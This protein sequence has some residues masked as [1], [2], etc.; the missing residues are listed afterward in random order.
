MKTEKEGRIS[1]IIRLKKKHQIEKSVR[2]AFTK[3]SLTMRSLEA[4]GVKISDLEEK[5]GLEH[6]RHIIK[7]E[8]A[9]STDLFSDDIKKFSEL[10]YI[11]RIEPV[12]IVRKTLNDVHR[13]INHPLA[14]NNSKYTGKGTRVAILDTGIDYSHPDLRKKVVHRIDISGDGDLDVDGH[15]THVAGIIAGSGETSHGKYKGIAP[16]A[17]LLNIKVLDQNGNG[18]SDDLEAGLEEAVNQKA[19]VINMSLGI[20]PD[21]RPPWIWPTYYYGFEEAAKNAMDNGVLAC[22]AAGN[23]GHLGSGTINSPGRIDEV[24]TV[25]STTKNNRISSFSSR[26]PVKIEQS[27]KEVKKPDVVAPVEKLT[28]ITIAHMSPALYHAWQIKA[29]V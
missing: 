15:G 26:G 18:R 17:S 25:G 14:S 13:L 21:E 2:F 7:S 19:D 27:K 5:S 29:K 3:P 12:F 24:L 11:E 22:I 20:E 8:N 9:F 28:V 16:E 4:T 1:V 10:P 23:S 6:V